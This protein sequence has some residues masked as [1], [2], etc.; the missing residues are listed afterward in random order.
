MNTVTAT[1]DRCGTTFEALAE[2]DRCV[3]CQEG[4]REVP[5]D[6]PTY[7]TR[8][9]PA[10]ED[11]R[12]DVLERDDR[13]CRGCG[14]SDAEHRQRDDLFGGGLHVHHIRPVTDFDDPDDAH[15]LSNLTVLCADCHRAVECGQTSIDELLTNER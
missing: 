8:H 5:D 4:E 11:I 14:I 15:R 3:P 13:E 6:S 10:F 1:C 12:D 7:A 9:G 2:H